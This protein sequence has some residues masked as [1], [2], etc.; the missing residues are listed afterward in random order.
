M[1]TI[2]QHNPLA[3]AANK[4]Q[5]TF[6]IV[7]ML[8]AFISASMAIMEELSPGKWKNVFFSFSIQRISDSMYANFVHTVLSTTYK[9]I[10]IQ[11]IQRFHTAFRTHFV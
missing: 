6:N 8:L 2:Q 10:C 9:T 3:M 4:W 1:K 7:L 11:I 5:N